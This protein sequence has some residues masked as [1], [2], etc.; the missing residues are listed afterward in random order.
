MVKKSEISK[1]KWIVYF[2]RIKEDLT[3]A[4]NDFLNRQS[5]LEGYFKKELNDL[6]DQLEEANQKQGELEQKVRMNQSRNHELLLGQAKTL[7]DELKKSQEMLSISFNQK[8][9][10]LREDKVARND[11]VSFLESLGNPIW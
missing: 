7:M 5:V 2:A 9:Q 3:E 11:L 4:R 6:K 10:T 1:K 8:Y